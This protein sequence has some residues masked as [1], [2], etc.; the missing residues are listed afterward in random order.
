MKFK[1]ITLWLLNFWVLTL[2]FNTLY[3]ADTISIIQFPLTLRPALVKSGENFTLLCKADKNIKSWSAVLY[4][5]F[6]TVQLQVTPQYNNSKALWE[7][8]AVVPAGT[9]VELYDLKVNATGLEDRVSHAVKVVQQF[10]DSYYFIHLPDLHLPAVSWI[11]YYDDNNTIPEFLQ[12]L[13]EISIINPEFVLQTGDIVDNGRE[14]DQYQLVQELLKKA[15]TP[16]FATGGNHDLWYNGHYYWNKYINPVMNYSFHYGAH[17]FAG[18]EMYDIPTVTFT[19]DQMRWVQSALQNSVQSNDKLRSLFYHYDESR[20]I[21][22]DFVDD[23][24]VDLILYGHTHLNGERTLGSRSTLNLNTSYTMNDVG[25]YRIIKVSNNQIQSYPLISFKNLNVVYSPANDG[26]NYLVKAVIKNHNPVSFENGLIKFM[27]KKDASGYNVTGGT[28]QQIIHSG[29]QDIYYVNVYINAEAEQ[30]VT[31]ISK[32]PPANDPPQ[33][34]NFSPI[35]DTTIIAGFPSQFSIGAL[36]ENKDNLRYKWYLDGNQISGASQSLYAFKP[37]RNFTGLVE[38]TARVADDEYYDEHTWMVQVDE[39]TNKPKVISSVV[40]FFLQ[41]EPMI[42][43]WLEPYPITARFEYGIKP[44]VYTGSIRETGENEVSF[45]PSYEGMGLGVHYCRITDGTVSSDP[46]TIIIESPNAPQ[47]LSPIGK[48]TDLSPLFT[49]DRVP[50]VPYYMVICSDEEIIISE[51]KE[52]REFTVEG[53]NP[54]WSVLTS[55]NSVPYGMPDPTG[56]FTSTPAPLVPGESYWWVVLNCYANSPEMTSPVQSGIS[57]FTINLPPPDLNPPELSSPANNVVLKGDIINFSWKKVEKAKAYHFYPFKI[58]EELGIETARAV[59]EKT[60]TTTETSYDY[61]AGQRFMKGRYRWKVAAVAENGL[62]VLSQPRDFEYDAPFA[63]ISIHTF[64]N[65]NTTN[66][67]SDDVNLPRVKINYTALDGVFNSMPLSTDIDAERVGYTISPGT[68]RFV[69]EKENYDT[70]VDTLS[71]TENKNY[72]LRFRL[73]PS[74]CSIIGTIKDEQGQAVYD[75]MVVAGHI[76]HT[77]IYKSTQTDA[78]GNFKCP[79]VPGPYEINVKKNGYVDSSPVSVSVVSG[80]EKV[81]DSDIILKKNTNYIS[82]LVVTEQQQPIFGV[83]VVLSNSVKYEKWTDANGHFEFTVPDGSF[84]LTA[85]KQGY[86]SPPSR[87]LTISGAGNL[88]ISPPLVLTSNAGILLGQVSSGS[89]QIKD[90]KIKAFPASGTPYET[91]TDVYGQFTLNVLPGTYTLTAEKEDYT[92]VKTVQVT[93]QTGETISGINIELSPVY[94]IIKGK[95]TIDGYTPLGGVD[96]SNSGVGTQTSESGVYELGVDEG[97]HTIFA[98]KEAFTSTPP[99]T[100]SVVAGQVVKNVNFILSPNASVIKG[101]ITA[102]GGGVYN[103]RVEA[104]NSQTVVTTSKEDGYFVLNLEAGEWDLKVTKIGFSQVEKKNVLVGTGQTIS[105]INFILQPNVAKLAGIVYEKNTS[106]AVKNAEVK[107]TNTDLSTT[108]SA[109]GSFALSVDPGDYNITINKTGYRSISVR[110]GEIKANQ[111]SGLE[112]YL[113][114]LSSN[115]TGFTHDMNNEPI[116]GVLILAFNSADTFQT[117][118]TKDG[119]YR[120]DLKSGLYQICAEK[121]GYKTCYLDA[122]KNIGANKSLKLPEFVLHPDRGNIHGTIFRRANSAPI[123]LARVTAKKNSG[124]SVQIQSDNNGIFTFKDETGNLLLHPGEYT[125][126]VT[127]SGFSAD[128]LDQ[129]QVSSDQNI[130]L[131]VVL[132]KKDAKIEGKVSCENNP[133]NGATIIAESILTKEIIKSLSNEDGIFEVKNL[134]SGEYELRIACTGFSSPK[135][136][137]VSTGTYQEISLIRNRGRIFGY[138]KDKETLQPVAG[139]NVLADDQ[140]GSNGTAKTDNNGYFDITA[141]PQT[142]S[143]KIFFSCSGYTP[144][145]YGPAQ[146]SDST[147]LDI[148]LEKIY[149]NISGLVKDENGLP[150]GG[151]FVQVKSSV[152]S[153]IDTTGS[154]GIFH[155]NHLAGDQYSVTARKIGFLSDPV[156][157]VVSLWQGGNVGGLAFEMK[158]A[159]AAQLKIIGPENINNKSIQKFIYSAKTTDLREASIDP[160]WE[161]DFIPGID[162]LNQNGILDPVNNFMGVMALKLTDLYTGNSIT[163]KIQITQE[164]VPG[165]T[166]LFVSN[167]KDLQLSIQDSC[168]NQNVVLLLR[169]PV[170]PSSMKKNKKYQIIGDVYQFSPANF[171]F[172]KPVKLSITVP[173]GKQANSL[174]IGKWSTKWL[175]WEV[176]ENLDRHNQ[177]L[178]VDV[179]ELG[180]FAIMEEA[181]PLGIRDIQ[182]SPNPFSPMVAPLEIKYMLTSDQ[183]DKPL[184]TI[185][186]YN[187]VGDLVKTLADAEFKERGENIDLWDGITDYGKMALNGRYVIHFKIKD[188]SGEKEELKSFVLIK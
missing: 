70:I 98:F 186:I 47:M 99:E 182:F 137:I 188:R 51:D 86:V 85:E 112:I 81:L 132:Q 20:Q 58:E 136:K 148:R 122:P 133:V 150:C 185:K 158:E 8:S 113:E 96:I 173:D 104:V 100:V 153:D 77:D 27:V 6:N 94:C 116:S 146:V 108:S 114:E 154:D 3:A 139:V 64:D 62:E 41:N 83:R 25:Q 82:G 16:M 134:L 80:E 59:W 69:V 43:K 90:A 79:V 179:N 4:S 144:V 32:N 48:I 171:N 35:A 89:T 45:T 65:K 157:Q 72:D 23:Y 42:L 138:V 184:V 18:M 57:K 151:V 2:F 5:D 103:A 152:F 84:E 91:K 155:F 52:T 165:N 36:D 107:I 67:T 68:Y 106:A 87:T 11:G 161:V 168:V 31:I 125:V 46:F 76:L 110:S 92:L 131:D 129:I 166:D 49:W 21:D 74:R 128:T 130:S 181:E 187:M 175:E 50:G 60:I 56:T 54:I 124:F 12:I 145:S 66:I 28:V 97:S 24:M 33:I 178:S 135:S 119:S 127:K 7:I 162:S 102:N 147:Y 88:K 101:R 10:K 115:F 167:K 117:L 111:T 1:T 34:T 156:E 53:A 164:L 55:E 93:V 44:G 170:L 61:P 169:K 22:D 141:L 13:K 39:Y 176:L 174:T 126:Y 160:L 9:P 121:E 149:G 180:R 38:L 183:T 19:A 143:Y 71:F 37:D 29:T 26:S 118:S 78:Q 75:A 120:L 17:F 15:N 63:T 95:V 159:K 163:Q 177:Q 142:N 40:N 123:P 172:L 105:G 30:E 109:D 73:S 14:G 140:N